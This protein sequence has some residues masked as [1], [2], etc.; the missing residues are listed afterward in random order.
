[1]A[2]QGYDDLMSRTDSRYRLSMIVA[3]RAAQLKRGFPS[4][5]PQEELPASGN[6]VSIALAELLRGTSLHWGE[7]LPSSDELLEARQAARRKERDDA[8]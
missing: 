5:L 2:Q 8:Y 4:L 7:D 6:T 3:N 1:M